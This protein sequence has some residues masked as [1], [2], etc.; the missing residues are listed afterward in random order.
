MA[1][2]RDKRKATVPRLT[3]PAIGLDHCRRTIG[4]I[5]DVGG[6]FP[7]RIDLRGVRR[8]GCLLG[9]DQPPPARD[10]HEVIARYLY[11]NAVLDQGRDSLGVHLLLSRVTNRLYEELGIAYL[12]DPLQFFSN[13][14]RVI[15]VIEEKHAEVREERASYFPR[16]TNYSLYDQYRVTPWVAFRWGAPLG[17]IIR[18]SHEVG[19]LLNWLNQFPSGEV[20]AMAI[21]SDPLFGLGGAIGEKA[22]R[23][24]VKWVAFTAQLALRWPP[25]SYEV[26]LDANVG[27][28]LMRTGYMFSFLDQEDMTK[29]NPSPWTLQEGGKVNLS[30]QSLNDRPLRRIEEIEDEL[31][32]LLER[33]GLGRSRSNIRLMKTLNVLLT[34][35]R[36]REAAIGQLDDGF[37]AVGRDICLNTDPE[38]N[39][40]PLNAVCIAN[41]RVPDLKTK[42]Y[43]GTGAGVFY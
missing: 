11:L 13:L 37:M 28:V 3:L 2:D 4:G 29:G 16:I 40:C 32:A 10:L 34:Q 8:I 20:A 41:Q 27:R 25:N 15:P 39:R 31:M 5:F 12:D 7:L 26:P 23:L 38:C 9:P 36:G 24:F 22:S 43:C 18:F 30:A 19:S 1:E 6:R 33:W 17:N 14:P 35:A 21:K 42:F